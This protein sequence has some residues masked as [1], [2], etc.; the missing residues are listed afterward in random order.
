MSRLSE[1][2]IAR[3]LAERED[4]EPP[5]G[6]LEKIKNEIP[7]AV[8]VGTEAPGARPS[9]MPMRQRWLIA[10]SL[11]AMVGAGLFAL[12]LRQQAPAL[13]TVAAPESRP[14]AAPPSR[15]ERRNEARSYRLLGPESATEAV[16]QGSDRFEKEADLE[17][18]AVSSPEPL[19][20]SPPPLPILS[21]RKLK[22]LGY[23]GGGESRDQAAVAPEEMAPPAAL[24]EAQNESTAVEGG[25]E[26]GVVGGVAGG[27]VGGTPGGIPASPP[28]LMD[29]RRQSTGATVSPTELEKI[30]T[31]RDSWDVMQK[32]PGVLTDKVNVGG[33]ESGQQS[34][35]VGPGSPEPPAR[36]D[37]FF[38]S[39]AVNPFVETAKDRLSTFGLDVDTAS[40]TVARGS[41]TEGSLPDP[42][43]VRVE[44]YVNF[45][46]YGD[47][48]PSRGDFAIKAE[49]APTPF[50][51]GERYRLLRFNIR[52]RQVKAEHRRPAV[53]TFVVD[54]SG[55]M[56]QQNRLGLVKQSLSL[57]L[58]QLRPVDRVGLVVYG[59]EAK[60]L[61]EPTNEREA[62][63]Q[64]IARL[65]S[66]GSTNAE[67]GLLL[68]YQVAVRNF[69]L[70]AANRIILCSDGVANVG[71][72]GPRAILGQ[73]EREAR[74]GIEL[75]TLGFGMGDYNDHLM[76]QLADK[77]DGRYAYI[78]TLDEARR[79][80]VE[81]L[82][83]TLQ[84]IAKDAKVQ[85][86]F[87]PQVVARYRLL[88]YENRDIADERFRDERVDAGEIGAGHGVTA[89]YEIELRP[90]APR[91]GLVAELHLRYRAPEIGNITE[92]I[93]KLYLSELA[94]SWGKASPGFRLA[95]LVAQ[96]AEILKQSPWARGDLNDVARQART[97]A[98][99]LGKGARL[100]ELADLA[101]KA[102]RIKAEAPKDQP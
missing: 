86:A 12:R 70:D 47:P 33:N 81:E 68:G 59:D 48:P 5:A 26:G 94:P 20:A 99:E 64:A 57:L 52:A 85:V 35:Y 23:V 42:R 73:I 6:L 98:G 95:A 75:T 63:R 76:E 97:A 44:E 21:E 29:R 58:D 17:A 18:A 62:V 90:D 93:R 69:R 30:P 19:P 74:R 32:T 40:Y 101:G 67:A 46:D 96:F 27:V 77:G 11:V 72:T 38:K 49:G 4:F 41:L 10:A 66:E 24:Q 80:L 34:Q 83:G 43:S 91:D 45:F 71:R 84:T 87:N 102:A 88:G 79:V 61:L 14:A 25:V 53:L 51:Q 22:S 65:R 8:S 15:E 100:S 55:S 82:T 13:E 1:R 37:A 31:A 9:V 3:K 54:V 60:L 50:T 56:D 36:A 16:P 89:L 92:T 2:E 28:P 78:D 7:P 39:T